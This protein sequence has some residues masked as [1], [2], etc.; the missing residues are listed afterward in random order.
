VRHKNDKIDNIR[1]CNYAFKEADELKATAALDPRLMLLKDLVSARI[2]LL[3]QRAGISVSL[4]ELG[5]VNG[6]AYQKVV[7]KTLRSAI[8]GIARSN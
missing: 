7:E 1:L 4:K 2:K 3:R 5:N 6:K 8:D